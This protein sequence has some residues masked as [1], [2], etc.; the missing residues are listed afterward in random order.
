MDANHVLLTN[1]P[2]GPGRVHEASEVIAGIDPVAV[3]AF[4]TDRYFDV[5]LDMVGHLGTAYDLGVGEI[6]LAK[7]KIKEFAA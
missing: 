3:D 1:G 7:L 5:R 2:S 6:D 4:T